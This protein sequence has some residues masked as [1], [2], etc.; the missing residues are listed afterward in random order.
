[1]NV[2][3]SRRLAQFLFLLNI[4]TMF[5]SLAYAQTT[6]QLSARYRSFTAFEIRPEIQARA[7]FA[8]S[9]EV[10]RIVIEKQRYRSSQKVDFDPVI[11][12]VLANELVDELVP[13]SERGKRVSPFLSSDSFIAGGTSFIKEDYENVSISMYGNELSVSNKSGAKV[14]TITWSKRTCPSE[15][16]Q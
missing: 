3:K 16:E 15:S 7:T 1:M 8:T 10:C 2:S 14:I 6:G 9:G 4:L 5:C 12:S 13:V 11:P